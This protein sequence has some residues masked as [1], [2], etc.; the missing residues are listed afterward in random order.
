METVRNAARLAVYVAII[1]TLNKDQKVTRILDE[2]EYGSI[3]PPVAWKP[4]DW[5]LINGA[6]TLQGNGIWET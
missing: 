2:M 3:A 5:S 4:N 6:K 1:M